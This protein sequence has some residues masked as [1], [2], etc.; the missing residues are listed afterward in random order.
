MANLYGIP[1]ELAELQKTNPALFDVVTKPRGTSA[2]SREEAERATAAYLLGKGSTS[3]GYRSGKPG[4]PEV[5]LEIFKGFKGRRRS[6]ES[7]I[8]DRNIIMRLEQTLDY[9]TLGD[10]DVKRTSNEIKRLRSRANRATQAVMNSM[11]MARH[12]NPIYARTV[13]RVP[14]GVAPASIMGIPEDEVFIE[15]MQGRALQL[16]APT[17]NKNYQELLDSNNRKDIAD[18]ARAYYVESPSEEE[19]QWADPRGDNSEE[20]QVKRDQQEAMS[21]LESLLNTLNDLMDQEVPT[22]SATREDMELTRN[23]LEQLKLTNPEAYKATVTGTAPHVIALLM[24]AEE[25]YGDGIW[26]ILSNL[27][28]EPD[29]PDIN[30]SKLQEAYDAWDEDPEETQ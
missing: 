16:D 21:G 9:Y 8:L 13:S 28:D 20:F 2:R 23:H 15:N 24:K 26:E 6:A 29:M 22:G 17:L 4:I 10:Y 3:P 7:C 30:K 12:Q 19:T 14:E 1:P 5:A 25:V 11:I 18:F 27:D